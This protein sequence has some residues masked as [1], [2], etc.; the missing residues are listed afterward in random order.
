MFRLGILV[1][2]P[3]NVQNVK[4]THCDVLYSEFQTQMS[5]PLNVQNVKVKNVIFLTE[6]SCT[7]NVQT[8]EITYFDIH[9]FEI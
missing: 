6:K 5:C 8:L 1:S 2:C 4:V 3:L 9:V 7:L